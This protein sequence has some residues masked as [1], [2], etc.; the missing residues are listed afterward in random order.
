M[1]VY[2][3]KFAKIGEKIPVEVVLEN[4]SDE[5]M[6]TIIKVGTSEKYSL[7]SGSV[8]LKVTLQKQGKR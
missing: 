1:A 2:G 3:P 8:N 6:E 7:G 5:L 4:V